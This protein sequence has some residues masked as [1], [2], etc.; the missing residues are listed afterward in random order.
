V[1]DVAAPEYRA[2]YLRPLGREVKIWEFYRAALARVMGVRVRSATPGELA[3]CHAVRREV[4]VEEQGVP[5][6]EEMDQRDATSRHFLAFIGDEVVGTARLR[7]TDNGSVK[8]ERV[9]VRRPF[10]RLGVCR[11]LMAAVE[12]AA[13]GRREIVLSAGVERGVLRAPRLPRR[14]R[15]VRRGRHPAPVDVEANRLTALS[16]M[17]SAQLPP[18][19]RMERSSQTDTR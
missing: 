6:E 19:S 15:R 9:A 13:R 14:G 10:R 5:I 16:R 3:G 18:F 7:T 8:A 4:F 2:R 1:K 12:H 17:G 11:A